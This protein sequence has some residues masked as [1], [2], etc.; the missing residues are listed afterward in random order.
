MSQF[1]SEDPVGRQTHICILYGK[2]DVKKIIV[3]LDL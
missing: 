3:D 1:E 2:K